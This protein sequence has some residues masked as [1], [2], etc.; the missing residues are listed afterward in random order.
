MFMISI[1]GDKKMNNLKT[2]RGDDV[3]LIGD[4]REHLF[5]IYILSLVHVFIFLVGVKLSFLMLLTPRKSRF[6]SKTSFLFVNFPMF[7]LRIVE[8][9]SRLASRVFY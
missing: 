8:N 1:V 7:L 9:S 4:V 2:S 3:V 6:R 5:S